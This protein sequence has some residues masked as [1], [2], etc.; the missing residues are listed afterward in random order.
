VNLPRNHI[1]VIDSRSWKYLPILH[2]GS[3]TRA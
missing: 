1:H 2:R 3:D